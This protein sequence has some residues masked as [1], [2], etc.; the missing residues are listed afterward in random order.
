MFGLCGGVCGNLCLVC[1]G[2]C[3]VCGEWVGS[4]DQGLD[5]GGVFCI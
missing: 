2:V 1:G 4:L 3:G 5:G